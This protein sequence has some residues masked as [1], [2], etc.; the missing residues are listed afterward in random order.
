MLAEKFIRSIQQSK[1]T[2][3]VQ[4]SKHW[5]VGLKDCANQQDRIPADIQ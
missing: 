4:I 2:R 3:F 5:N 1:A